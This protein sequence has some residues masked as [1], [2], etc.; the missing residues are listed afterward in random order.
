[1]TRLLRPLEP[2]D[3]P[4][5]ARI[6]AAGFARAWPEAD[7]ANWLTG[8]EAFGVL[9]LGAGDPL[10]FAIARDTG[11]DAE[12]LSIASLPGVRRQGWA[13]AALRG[14]VRMAAARRHERMLLEV[15]VANSGAMALYSAEG[16]VEIGRRRGY[17]NEPSG[18]A[19]ALVMACPLAP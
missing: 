15:S 5:L 11:A 13:R 2:G 17:Y 19:D 4:A 1:M 8:Q 9:G 3:A 12:L 7:F 10:A 14:V 6:H 18:P 16:F